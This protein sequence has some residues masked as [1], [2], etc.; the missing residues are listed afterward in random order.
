MNNSRRLFWLS[1]VLTLLISAGVIA[2][3]C[4][5]NQHL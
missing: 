1:A 2:T 4:W 5:I 3:G